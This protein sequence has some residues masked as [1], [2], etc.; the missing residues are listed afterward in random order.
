MQA[1][2]IF[3]LCDVETALVFVA[4]SAN[5]LASVAAYFHNIP[6]ELH[7]YNV[8]IRSQSANEWMEYGQ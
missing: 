7:L 8:V 3:N 6:Q 5:N 4:G 1:I 2:V